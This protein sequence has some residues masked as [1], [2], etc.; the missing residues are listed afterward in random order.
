MIP[1][2]QDMEMF[3]IDRGYVSVCSNSLK[4]MLL[5]ASDVIVEILSLGGEFHK[6]I[7]N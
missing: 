3:V 4:K 5:L 7:D 1:Q 2:N 6:S